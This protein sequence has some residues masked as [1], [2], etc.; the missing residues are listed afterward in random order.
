MLCYLQ[1]KLLLEAVGDTRRVNFAN[2]AAL[3]N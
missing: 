2:V 1:L 3:E